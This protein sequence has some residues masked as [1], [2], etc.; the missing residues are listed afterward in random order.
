MVVFLFMQLMSCGQR[1]DSV[2][3]EI[4]GDADSY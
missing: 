3:K 2:A 1:A 4:I